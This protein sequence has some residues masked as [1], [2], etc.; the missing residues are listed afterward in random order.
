[1]ISSKKRDKKGQLTIFIILGIILAISIIFV[2]FILLKPSTKVDPKNN[3]EGYIIDCIEDAISET[4]K[5]IMP[6]AGHLTFN[7][8]IL[9]NNKEIPYLCHTPNNLEICKVKEPQLKEFIESNIEEDTIDT[10]ENCFAE[11]REIFSESSY[12]QEATEYEIDISKGRLK[13]TVNKQISFTR[14]GETQTINQFVFEKASSIYDLI[15]L[16]TII[17]TQET[18]CDCQTESCS[19]DVLELSKLNRNFEINL[20]VTSQNE[21]IYNMT[22]I[23][24]NEKFA[25]SVRNCVRLP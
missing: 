10:I 4:E 7:D 3:P 11:L 17:L 13:A 20:F 12:S 24:N 23:R 9:F 8:Y 25:F 19:S 14:D 21:K 1:M 6:Q 16:T 2:F 18:L 22:D 5:N 15:V